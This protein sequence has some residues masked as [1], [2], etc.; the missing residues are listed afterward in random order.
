VEIAIVSSATALSVPIE[1]TYGISRK[2]GGSML[3]SFGKESGALAAAE[4]FVADE[5]SHDIQI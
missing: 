3:L 5:I 1:R 2:G 4:N